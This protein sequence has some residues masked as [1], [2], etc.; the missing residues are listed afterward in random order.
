MVRG[1]KS[2]P[3]RHGGPAVEPPARCRLGD[4]LQCCNCV[5]TGLDRSLPADTEIKSAPRRGDYLTMQHEQSDDP[6][7]FWNDEPTRPLKRAQVGTRSHGETRMVPVVRTERAKPVP[8]PP[9][10][11]NPLMTRVC[12]ML[13]SMM[14]LVPIALS[15]R[16]DKQAVRAAEVKATDTIFVGTMPPAP[17]VVTVAPDTQA[18]T[19]MVATTAAPTTPPPT[20][21]APTTAAPTDPPTT[22]ATVATAAKKVAPKPPTTPAPAPPGAATQAVAAPA[23]NQTYT[24]AAGDAWSTIA[25]RAKISMTSL[26]AANGATTQTLLLPGKKVCLP[27]G[28]TAPGPPTTKPPAATQPATTQPKAITPPITPATTQAPATPASTAPA[29]TQ[30]APPANIYSKAQVAQ[31]IREVWPD[32]L[33][34]EAIR[35]A[36]RESGLVPTVHNYCCY[37]LFQI[38]YTAHKTW[39]AS[40][41]ITSAA[42]LYDPRVNATAA[43]ALYNS[44]GWTPWGTPTTTTTVSV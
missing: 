35:I 40:I 1:F 33:E 17:T 4:A 41:G 43:L 10:L 31:I 24:V 36:T 8:E 25:A 11:H 44:N 7:G 38:Y 27:D 5:T 16:N 9:R 19:T 2:H 39:L 42:Q 22:A 28:A 23:C 37:G 32:T 12:V 26:L 20:E 14:L 34:D 3:L 21:A 13:G 18:P 15:L 6:W 29:T 30:P